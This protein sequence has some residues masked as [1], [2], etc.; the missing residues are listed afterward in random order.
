MTVSEGEVGVGM[1]ARLS[2]KV[3]SRVPWLDKLMQCIGWLISGR[4][5]PREVKKPP[6]ANAVDRQMN[7]SI[8]R[9]IHKNKQ[10]REA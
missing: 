3:E 7:S 6:R 8:E 4:K 9:N 1:R 2:A 10:I 5:N